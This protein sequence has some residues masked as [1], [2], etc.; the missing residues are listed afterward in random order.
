VAITV[1][2]VQRHARLAGLRGAASL[3]AVERRRFQLWAVMS[4][5]L[6]ALSLLVA[7]T[8]L[9]PHTGAYAVIPPHVLQLGMV[10]LSLGFSVYVLEKERSLRRV[11]DLLVEERVRHAELA[12]E[13]RRLQDLVA[14]GRAMSATLEM[15]RVVELVLDHAL[16]LFDAHSGSVLLMGPEGRLRV[17]AA[18]G[19]AEREGHPM[20]AMA[21]EV[22]RTRE[23]VLAGAGVDGRDEQRGAGRGMS[24]PLTADR[25]LVGVLNI[26]AGPDRDFGDL[27]L[28][29]LEAFGEHAATAIGNAARFEE[30][31]AA[32]HRYEQL[33]AVRQEFRWLAR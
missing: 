25:R 10:A 23:A 3:E 24:V 13:T 32:S 33:E 29:V 26:H 14:A 1:R 31:R 18:R 7:V 27:D 20:E 16:R 9:W 5:C 8:S 6:V 2:E 17:E 19:T 11:S 4:A 28:S 21:R 22:A 15:E 12:R 30:E